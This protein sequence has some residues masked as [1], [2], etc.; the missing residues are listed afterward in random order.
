[1][2][3]RYVFQ[4]EHNLL[5]HPTQ[6]SRFVSMEAT[7]EGGDSEIE[8]SDVEP[9]I[10]DK[11]FVV[12][13][14]EDLQEFQESQEEPVEEKLEIKS[15][16]GSEREVEEGDVNEYKAD[17]AVAILAKFHSLRT[18]NLPQE[19]VNEAIDLLIDFHHRWRSKS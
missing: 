17:R 10:E 13:E 4:F 14:S 11:Q 18:L 8:E 1:M 7:A 15:E 5:K 19:L 6:M 3:F 12:Q 9:T 16:E 2:N